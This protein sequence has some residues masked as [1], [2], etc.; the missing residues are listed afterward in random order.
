MTDN[1]RKTFVQVVMAYLRDRVI[2]VANERR[3]LEK[4]NRPYAATQEQGR[5]IELELLLKEIDALF[6]RVYE[7]MK[8]RELKFQHLAD[9]LVQLPDDAPIRMILQAGLGT[10]APMTTINLRVIDLK[11]FAAINKLYGHDVEEG[12]IKNE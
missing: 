10:A 9:M 2:H 8:P 5:L 12:N 4:D 11:H 1:L 3:I 7:P 6:E